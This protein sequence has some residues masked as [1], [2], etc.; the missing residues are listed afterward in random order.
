MS[1]SKRNMELGYITFSSEEQQLVHDVLQQINQNQG[2]IDELGLG[3][4]RDAFSDL[5]FPGMST[6]HRKSKYFVLLPALY[7]QLAQ[8][9]ITDRKQISSLIR[10]W[11]INMTI[12][13]LNGN[14][15]DKHIGITGSS[16]D[17]DKLRKNDFVKIRPTHIYLSSL[18]FFG[19]VDNKM[20]LEDLIYQQSQMKAT[21][22]IRRTKE[23]GEEDTDD[24]NNPIGFAPNFFP[25]SGYDFSKESAI[26]LQLTANEAQILR[27]QII[28]KCRESNKGKDN[29]YSYILNDKDKNIKIVPNFFDMSVIIKG[30]PEELSKVYKMAYDF[31]KWAHLMNTYYRYAFYSKMNPD[32][33]QAKTNKANHKANIDKIK[34]DG[35]YPQKARLEEILDFISP[36]FTDVNGLTKFCIDASNH[37]EKNQEDELI[38]LIIKRERDIKRDHY[39]IGNVR[40]KN[41]NFSDPPGYYTYR[42]NEIVYSMIDDIRKAQ[43]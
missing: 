11:E 41:T 9:T 25:F 21:S 6:L 38:G 2:A 40:Y 12:S 43:L 36:E 27:E 30:F 8:T 42:W 10:Q 37:R 24:I 18:K 33:A 35:D 26:S 13:L 32:D 19:L 20:N 39:K 4:I 31:S 14:A 3:R 17:I 7:N 5:M 28:K 1:I 16:K 29:L 15:P 22:K 23:R 34:K